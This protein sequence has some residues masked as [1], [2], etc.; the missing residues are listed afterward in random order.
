MGIQIRTK[1]FLNTQ[2]TIQRFQY[3][4][5]MHLEWEPNKLTDILVLA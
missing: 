4:P 5:E 3:H 1:N 2:I